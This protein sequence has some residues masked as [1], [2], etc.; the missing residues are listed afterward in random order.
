MSLIQDYQAS[1]RERNGYLSQEF[2]SGPVD[3]A[4]APFKHTVR[5]GV[6]EVPLP[7][8]RLLAELLAAA[9]PR[10]GLTLAALA[11][12]LWFANGLLRRKFDVDWARSAAGQSR[13]GASYARGTSSGGGLYPTELYLVAEDL[14]GLP[15]GIYHHC[16]ARSA[17]QRT[18]AGRYGPALCATWHGAA[19][20]GVCH[21]VLTTR[22]WKNVFKYKN[23]G[24]QLMTEDCGAVVGTLLQALGDAGI[25]A[26]VRF[27]FA[28][29]DVAGLMGL[30]A[31]AE[32]P[33]IV[34][35]LGDGPLL[36]GPPRAV[37]RGAPA[38]APLERSRRVAVPAL[39]GELHRATLCDGAA[40]APL[41][42]WDGPY[43]ASAWEALPAGAPIVGSARLYMQ[44]RS[45]M[46]R[47]LGEDP[48]TRHELATLLAAAGQPFRS[49][50]APAAAEPRSVRLAAYARHVDALAPGAYAYCARRH[51]LA[52][53][54][55]P[56]DSDTDLQRI[57]TMQNYNINQ[58]GLLL[59]VV[60]RHAAA[61]AAWGGRSIRIC[62]GEAGMAAQRIYLAAAQLGLSCGAVLGFHCA[63][64]DRLF[65]LDRPDESIV[66]MLLVA[67]RPGQQAAFDSRFDG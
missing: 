8:G 32:V 46:G 31:E 38:P 15:N 53:C 60:A 37:P 41:P 47:Q 45:S 51:A 57:Y 9:G 61:Y 33:M 7:N 42:A 44:R 39:I 22:F 12:V 43:A 54:A 13:D 30:D 50:L 4:D 18:R 59:A 6:F 34:I 63:E 2:I 52:A 49:D 11:Q 3:W 16:E 1:F 67:R 55:G 24:Y 48:L 27:N 66:L 29:R 5:R 36:A 35:E 21:L 56:D 40:P 23:F 65:G 28:D 17:L 14:P 19:R 64:A 25:A 62:N 58:T 10:P 20:R 26:A